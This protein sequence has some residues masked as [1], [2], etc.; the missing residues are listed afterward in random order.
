MPK[1]RVHYDIRNSRNTGG[2]SGNIVVECDTDRMA[3]ML[4]DGRHFSMYPNARSSGDS[5]VPKRIEHIG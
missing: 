4:A 3:P 2:T 5:F 1:F